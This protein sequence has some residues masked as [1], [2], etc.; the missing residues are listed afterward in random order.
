M[1]NQ[2]NKMNS[3]E[4]ADWVIR[5]SNREVLQVKAGSKGFKILQDLLED[6]AATEIKQKPIK[7]KVGAKI[8]G[9]F[10]YPI[11]PKFIQPYKTPK[12][13]NEW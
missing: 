7:N 13:T 5:N 1:N 3:E 9:G 4:I 8:K 12:F 10:T 11:D 6:V 2:D